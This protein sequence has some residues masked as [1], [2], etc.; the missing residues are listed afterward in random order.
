MSVISSRLA[1]HRCAI[2][3]RVRSPASH[4]KRQ[5]A[6]MNSP[7]HCKNSCR[8]RRPGRAEGEIRDL[9]KGT[10]HT[11]LRSSRFE[12][13]AL[14]PL[15][16]DDGEG[17]CGMMVK[18]AGDKQWGRYGSRTSGSSRLRGS[19]SEQAQSRVARNVFELGY[20]EFGDRNCFPVPQ[21]ICHHFPYRLRIQRLGHA[22]PASH[23]I[24]LVGFQRLAI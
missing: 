6:F 9:D 13:P 3:S 14:A 5:A 22:G 10:A 7:N 23:Y 15:G 1:G 18:A 4:Q 19:A 8:L 24:L 17:G 21:I 20:V 16:Q 11:K 2:S 12:I